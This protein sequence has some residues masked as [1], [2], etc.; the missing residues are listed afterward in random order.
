[1]ALGCPKCSATLPLFKSLLKCGEQTFPCPS[2]DT[3]LKTQLPASV[4]P[5]FVILWGLAG[6]PFFAIDNIYIREIFRV[7]IGLPIFAMMY[8]SFGSVS[9][10]PDNTHPPE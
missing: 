7:A 3:K 4:F 6:I 2:C 9:L 1:M 8:A 5:S 10:A